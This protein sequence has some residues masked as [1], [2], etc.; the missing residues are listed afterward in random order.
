MLHQC[1]G[2]EAFQCTVQLKSLAYIFKLNVFIDSLHCNYIR[3][4]VGVLLI[5]LLC[6]QYQG[7][8]LVL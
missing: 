6:T 1:A 7:I 4:V 5:Y 3:A 8:I 2:T